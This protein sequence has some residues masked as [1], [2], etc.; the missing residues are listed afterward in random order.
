MNLSLSGS[1]V[2]TMNPAVSAPP[3]AGAAELTGGDGASGRPSAVPSTLVASIGR[4]A[5]PRQ[6]TI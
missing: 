4:V 5:L 6:A 1:D 2:K 3:S